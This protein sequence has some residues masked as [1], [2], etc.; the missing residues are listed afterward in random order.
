MVLPFTIDSLNNLSF[1]QVRV[2]DDV[3]ARRQQVA[4]NKERFKELLA[5]TRLTR[6]STFSEFTDKSKHDPRYKLIEKMIERD[7]LF[8]EHMA[9]LRKGIEL[10]KKPQL[11][12]IVRSGV[13]CGETVCDTRQGGVS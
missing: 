10:A 3:A 4:Q 11:S 13:V 9:N 1:L 8:K 12:E 2:A 6:T 5:E 7:Q